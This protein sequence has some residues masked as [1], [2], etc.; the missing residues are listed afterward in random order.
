MSTGKGRENDNTGSYRDKSQLDE[1]ST[2]PY[3]TQPSYSSNEQ[4][5]N[6]HE[7]DNGRSIFNRFVVCCDGTMNESQV[8]T[9]VFR[10]SEILGKE[11]DPTTSDPFTQKVYYQPGI[12]TKG[13]RIRCY[14][15]AYDG[16]GKLAIHS[17]ALSIASG[18][19]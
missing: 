6:P 10:I 18:L 5:R 17:T 16:R 11:K 9:N 2:T 4:K 15:N 1:A 19:I 12:G 14:L 8:P 3:E 13:N 7:K